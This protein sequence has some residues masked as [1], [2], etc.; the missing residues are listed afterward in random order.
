MVNAHVNT[1]SPALR[2]TFVKTKKIL[3]FVSQEKI[4][5]RPISVSIIWFVSVIAA[6][7]SQNVRMKTGVYL[8]RYVNTTYALQNQENA[9]NTRIVVQVYFVTT[10][11]VRI[12][13]TTF[14]ALKDNIVAQ[15][16]AEKLSA[17]MVSNAIGLDGDVRKMCV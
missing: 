4:V 12:V 2:V 5:M 10:V 11:I 9:Q 7:Q 16:G 17:Q 1:K 6:F 14:I 8:D 3:A 15:S 13:C